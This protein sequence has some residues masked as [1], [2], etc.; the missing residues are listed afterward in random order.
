MSLSSAMSNAAYLSIAPGFGPHHRAGPDESQF[1]AIIT[2]GAVGLVM[3]TEPDLEGE[4]PVREVRDLF[5]LLGRVV[6]E[7][8]RNPDVATGDGDV[9]GSSSCSALRYVRAPPGNRRSKFRRAFSPTLV[10]LP[11]DVTEWVPQTTRS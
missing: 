4:C 10:P 8:V 11:W 5:G 1:D 7:A 6:L 2:T 9:H 3:P